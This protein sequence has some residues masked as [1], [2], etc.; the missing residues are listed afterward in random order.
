M[1]VL[2]MGVSGSGKT[3]IGKVLA[4]RL[5]LPFYD[6]DNYHSEENIKKMSHGKPLNDEDRFPWLNQL[7]NLLADWEADEGAVL[8]CSA[9]KKSYRDILN[10]KAEN[11]RWVYLS[12]DLK[13]I[14]SRMKNRE[15]HFMKSEM[16][17]SQFDDLEPP[18]HAI[19]ISI[20][21]PP[22]TII[23]LLLEKLKS[24]G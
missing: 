2:V 4:K 5:R 19:E 9:L 22:E 23:D 20:K 21:N 13:T 8:A 6:S 24:N 14:Q 11:I 18:M 15:D 3:T 17:T 10:S 16:L 7:A 1:I 12:G